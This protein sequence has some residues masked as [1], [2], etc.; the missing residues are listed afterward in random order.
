M[1]LTPPFIVRIENTP[2]GSFGVTMNDIRV[3]LDHQKIEPASFKPVAKAGHGIGFEFGFNSEEQ[4]RL[5]AQAFL[6]RPAE[7]PGFSVPVASEPLPAASFR[8]A[9]RE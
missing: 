1:A 9:V 3:W 7:S 6:S 4:A 8:Q 2:E 5:F